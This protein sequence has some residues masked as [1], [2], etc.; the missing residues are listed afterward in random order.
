MDSRRV[1]EIFSNP[2]SATSNV[3]IEYTEFPYCQIA[4]L[5]DLLIC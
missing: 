5:P 4:L 1:E 3:V 2:Q